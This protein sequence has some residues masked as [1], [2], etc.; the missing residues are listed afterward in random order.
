MN[1]QFSFIILTYNEERH[2]PRLLNSITG[3]NAETFVLDSGSTDGTI[4]IAEN[5]GA[6]IA[7]HAF[8]NHPRQW[9]FALKN[10][11]VK[12]PWVIC[13]DADQI[14][15]PE[16][17]VLLQ[18]FRDTDYQ[19]INGIYFNRKNF[20]KGR[21]IRHGG[22]Y[23]FYLLKMIRFGI[24]FSDTNENMDHR[25]VVQGNTLIWKNGHI[26]EENLKENKISFWIAKH[27]KYSDLLAHEEIERMQS[28]RLQTVKPKFW[29]SPDERTAWLKQRWWKLPRYARPMLYFLYRIIFKLGILDGRTGLIFHFM[30]AFWFRLVVDIKIDELLKQQQSD[31]Q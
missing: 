15:T 17:F 8:I 14:V 19:S 28:I 13:L 22:Y 1:S 26:L 16:L 30:Q 3:L 21:W 11:E 5:A 25:L 24:G 2:L 29:G 20:F 4:V 12:T 18:N 31:G 6:V 7:Q 9:D 23:P 27:N 10:F